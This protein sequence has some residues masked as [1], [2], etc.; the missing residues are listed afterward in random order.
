MWTL[1]EEDIIKK[2][3]PYGDREI[4]L[5]YLPDKTW[6]NIGAKARRMN[7]LRT[8][9]YWSQEDNKWLKE[10]YHIKTINEIMLKFPYKTKQSIFDH[11]FDLG[12]TFPKTRDMEV[13]LYEK[14]NKKSGVFGEL[15]WYDYG[16]CW[17]WTGGLSGNGYGTFSVQN[18]KRKVW[19]HRFVYELLIGP[20][21][22]NMEIDHLCRIKKCVNPDHLQ[23]VIS[24]INLL[25]AQLKETHCPFGHIRNKFNTFIVN[26]KF[27][28][29]DC[30]SINYI[31]KDEIY[32]DNFNFYRKYIEKE[33][34]PK[35][36]S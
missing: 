19:A 18:C 31:Y 1:Y 3:Y 32:D 10:F 28:C 21:T 22:Q 30:L 5:K 15:N 8:R 7:I 29:K 9:H 17:I 34:C 24:K 33:S 16:E 14:I 11:A 2:Y 25:R 4:I 6:A 13:R 23:P 27:Y 36:V 20:I 26:N 12:L 35:L